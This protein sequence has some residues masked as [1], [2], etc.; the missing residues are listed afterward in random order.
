MPRRWLISCDG[1]RVSATKASSRRTSRRWPRTWRNQR[2]RSARRRPGATRARSADAA[3][4][5]GELW[6]PLHG[7]PFTLK[8]MIDRRG[9][10]Q[11]RSARARRSACP[12][13]DGVIAERLKCAGGILF[14][15]TNMANMVQTVSE[16]FG[17]TSNPYDRSRTTG[18][19]SGGAA[20][21][22]AARLSPFDV[23]TDLSGSI[24]MPA[25]F[26]G[27]FGFRPTTHRIP[28]PD[29]VQGPPGTPRIDRTF[30]TA[31]PIA[32]SASDIAL[33]F[34]VL[35]GPDA[36][37][38]EVP[39]VATG[40][41]SPIGLAGLRVALA[42]SIAGI[43]LANEV[44]AAIARLGSLLTAAGATSKRPRWFPSTS[45]S[46]PFGA[47]SWWCWRGAGA[48]AS[49]SGTEQIPDPSLTDALAAALE[50]DGYLARAERFFATARRLDRTRRGGDGVRTRAAREPGHG[51]RPI[52]L[53]A[54]RRPSHA[55]RDL[56]GGTLARRPHRTRPARTPHRSPA[57][58]EPWH[59]E[60]LLA[61]GAAVG[62]LVGALP[63][64]N[65]SIY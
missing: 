42:P 31:G 30:G 64:P 51:R 52:G 1:R 45:C 6:G 12:A 2:H 63:A 19:S 49:P 62:D 57:R 58:G 14:G 9:R 5:R 10:R 50:R 35:A 43:T 13:V 22:V 53:V 20:A 48:R 8:D 3:I 47:H 16:Q 38:P 21:A 39:N 34:R 33:L 18:G 27:V 36:R 54:H 15:K 37:D 28:V 40:D 61:I 24:R 46:A 29:L 26:C 60:R 11:R 25:H 59:D 65:L 56:C 7:V 23:G 55:P 4:A 32:R 44:S 41:I 17:R